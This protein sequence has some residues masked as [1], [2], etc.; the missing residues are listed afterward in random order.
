M[1]RDLPTGI[2]KRVTDIFSSETLLC[3]LRVRQRF[4]MIWNVFCYHRVFDTQYWSFS[5]WLWS[6]GDVRVIK[7][8][9]FSRDNS[10]DTE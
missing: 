2:F 8:E 3:L 9:V 4:R 5:A 7:K 1:V 10:I 6:Y